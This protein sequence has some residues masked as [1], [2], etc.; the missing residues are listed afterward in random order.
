MGWKERGGRSGTKRPWRKVCE[1]CGGRGELE[2]VWWK[3]CSGKGI[4][5]KVY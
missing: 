4:V 2:R 1:G 5:E 3:E